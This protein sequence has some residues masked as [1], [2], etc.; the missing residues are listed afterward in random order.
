MEKSEEIEER[1]SQYRDKLDRLLDSATCKF[2]KSDRRN[3]RDVPGVYIIYNKA[4]E[5][6][7]YVGESGELRRRLFGDHMAGNRRG[8]AFRRA[9][10]RW[11]KMKE[12]QKISHYI[13]QNCSFKALAVQDKLQRKRFE[14]FIIAVLNPTLNDVVKLK[15]V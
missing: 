14:H 13:T 5:R 12:E 2:S 4:D 10:S 1:I 6:V 9:L 8:S 7:L 11:E 3:F 15:I